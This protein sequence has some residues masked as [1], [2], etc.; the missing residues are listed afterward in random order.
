MWWSNTLSYCASS[1]SAKTCYT[2]IIFNFAVYFTS[3]MKGE[4]G[5]SPTLCTVS[6]YMWDEVMYLLIYLLMHVFFCI[7]AQANNVNGLFPQN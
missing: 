5:K 1:Y 6:R 4:R 3:K 2:Y 7:I